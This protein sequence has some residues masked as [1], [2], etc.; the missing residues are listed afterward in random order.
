MK[1]KYLIG[2]ATRPIGG[3]TKII[4]HIVNDMG[5]W[6][7]GFVLALSDRWPM[8][9]GVSSPEYMYREWKKKKWR[10]RDLVL[11]EIQTIWVEDTTFVCNM[12]A[13]RD[14]RSL[15]EEGV[16]L[17]LPNVKYSSLLECLARL[18]IQC[19]NSE[20]A[21]KDVSI[22]MPRIGSGLGGGD[23]K[24]I[25]KIINKEL[26]YTPFPVYVYDQKPVEGTEY[27]T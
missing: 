6:G 23:W 2:D 10:G 7:R 16:K 27:S 18:R 12:V 19:I 17:N 25:E 11:G 1:I 20:N 22:H 14:F 5:G 8:K 15:E 24:Q 13:Q 3:G 4:A 21:G 9:N 26:D